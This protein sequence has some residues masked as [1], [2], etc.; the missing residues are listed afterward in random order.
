MRQL[1]WKVGTSSFLGTSL[2]KTRSAFTKGHFWEQLKRWCLGLWKVDKDGGG[3]LLNP[4]AGG[5]AGPE[6]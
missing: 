5:K 2:I 3:Y 6:L 1:F 4:E